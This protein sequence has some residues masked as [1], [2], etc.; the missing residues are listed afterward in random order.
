MEE[1][2]KPSAEV[3]KA[4]RR[5][6]RIEEYSYDDPEHGRKVQ[7]YLAGGNVIKNIDSVIESCVLC[8][9]DYLGEDG[10]VVF[11][12]MRICTRELND[13]TCILLQ[14]HFTHFVKRKYVFHFKKHTDR[15]TLISKFLSYF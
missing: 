3:I 15:R 13:L 2:K 10:E 5:M 6:R 9:A 14:H 7:K 8:A 12:G 11:Q 4:T 1:G